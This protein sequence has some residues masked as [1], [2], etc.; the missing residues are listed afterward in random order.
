MKSYNH[1]TSTTTDLKLSTQYEVTDAL[2]KH[3]TKFTDLNTTGRFLLIS[4]SSTLGGR[5]AEVKT[6]ITT[7]SKATGAKW[8]TIRDLWEKLVDLGYIRET[9]DQLGNYHAYIDKDLI[10]ATIEGCVVPEKY[11]R[12]A[13]RG[14]AKNS[15]EKRDT[16]V[17]A[18]Y[19]PLIDAAPVGVQPTC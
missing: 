1:R 13:A 6:N 2:A 3:I 15:V 12:G 16:K 5:F 19:Q 4:V 9:T 10:R 8:E 11:K 14:A 7:Y 18:L 17:A